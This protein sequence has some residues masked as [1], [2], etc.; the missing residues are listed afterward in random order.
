V[1]GGSGVGD[2]GGWG[3]GW[4]GWGR[5]LVGGRISSVL[6]AALAHPQSDRALGAAPLRARDRRASSAF[7]LGG[8]G[9]PPPPPCLDAPAA[10]DSLA[11]FLTTIQRS[12]VSRYS[13]GP[14]SRR[15]SLPRASSTRRPNISSLF[16]A[17]SFVN[18]AF[19]LV[20]SS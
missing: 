5:G 17:K 11:Q 10:V 12:S 13:E 14:L 20:C 2:G 1:C 16:A 8:A 15:W 4:G 18:S 9:P 6:P 7:W 3:W 19:L